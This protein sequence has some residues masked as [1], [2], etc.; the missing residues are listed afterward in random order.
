M[1]APLALTP[2]VA[3]YS[4]SVTPAAL[5]DFCVIGDVVF[6]RRVQGEGERDGVAD[7]GAQA[8]GSGCQG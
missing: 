6:Y 4:A 1:M 8:Q 2:A 5:P 3:T 7:R